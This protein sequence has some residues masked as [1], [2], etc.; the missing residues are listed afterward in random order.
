MAR[1]LKAKVAMQAIG[2]PALFRSKLLSTSGLM[3]SSLGRVG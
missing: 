1:A 3:S 2:C